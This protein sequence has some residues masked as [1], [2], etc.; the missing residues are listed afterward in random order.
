MM[1][2]AMLAAERRT[3]NS[4]PSHDTSVTYSVTFLSDM[5]RDLEPLTSASMGET[6]AV[7]KTR[8]HMRGR[9]RSARPG[10]VT[11][12]DHIP[13]GMRQQS[14][15]VHLCLFVHLEFHWCWEKFWYEVQTGSRVD[16]TSICSD[17]RLFTYTVGYPSIG[18]ECS[19]GF[20]RY[21]N[22]SVFSQVLASALMF[23]FRRL[24]CL[25]EYQAE[26]SLSIA[27]L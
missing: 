18:S 25:F 9:S 21:I 22:L 10:R 7:A 17:L 12:P 19:S 16:V 20:V 26:R 2:F 4:K 27:A 8:K 24:P 5:M 23:P 1:V 15:M 11:F 13:S 14:I 6:N 3:M